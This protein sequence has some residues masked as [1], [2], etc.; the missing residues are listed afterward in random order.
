MYLS[1][2][3]HECSPSKILNI[4]NTQSCVLLT[5]A[6]YLCNIFYPPSHRSPLIELLEVGSTLVQVKGRLVLEGRADFKGYFQSIS[7]SFDG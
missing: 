7:H 4:A 5:Y 2:I 1:R 6:N 3:G